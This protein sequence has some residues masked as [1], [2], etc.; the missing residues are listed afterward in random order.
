MTDS[1]GCIS[2]TSNILNAGFVGIIETI[3]ENSISIYPNPVSNE[4]II[5]IEG[6]TEKVNF[7]I[8]NAIGQIILNGDFIEKINVQTSNFLPGV[9][10]IKIDNGKTI[11][12]KKIIKE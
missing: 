4:L 8:L 6:K 9:Y 3:N 1:L 10:L 11:E 7:E 2:D 12:M 5:E